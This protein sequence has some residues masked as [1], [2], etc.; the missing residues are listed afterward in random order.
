MGR[1][2]SEDHLSDVEQFTATQTQGGS[3]DDIQL[4]LQ[5]TFERYQAKLKAQAIKNDEK[6]AERIKELEAKCAGLETKNRKLQAD[7]DKLVRFAKNMRYSI[8]VES[9]PISNLIASP[10][11]LIESP[12]RRPLGRARRDQ[13]TSEPENEDEDEGE[14]DIVFPRAGPSKRPTK[15]KRR[16][17][18]GWSSDSH[19]HCDC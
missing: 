11:R 17:W 18:S 14:D 2:S 15:P 8:E 1:Q 7:N 3:I 4:E 13:S 5:R 10:A 12:I 9:D 6:K 19:L 16:R